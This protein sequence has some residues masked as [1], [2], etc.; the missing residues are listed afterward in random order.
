VEQQQVWVANASIAAAV[1][2]RCI[3]ETSFIHNGA[4]FMQY[5]QALPAKIIAL[6]APLDV[7]ATG[8]KL[9]WQTLTQIQ[10]YVERCMTA[11]STTP[12]SASPNNTEFASSSS[13]SAASASESPGEYFMPTR[14]HSYHSLPLLHLTP[15]SPCRNNTATTTTSENSSAR[16]NVPIQSCIQVGLFCVFALTGPSTS[17]SS[18]HASSFLDEPTATRSAYS[19][20]EIG[21]FDISSLSKVSKETIQQVR[22]VEVLIQIDCND[23]A[24]F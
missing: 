9:F 10:T 5:L 18:S 15:S 23:C 14:L 4:M 8:I 13:S 19:F 11:L 21:G 24:L 3:D 1:R 7:L 6:N 22:N 17:S 16:S 2:A 20:A 12:S